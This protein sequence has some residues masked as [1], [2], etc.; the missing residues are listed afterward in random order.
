MITTNAAW[1]VASPRRAV[2]IP[3][4]VPHAHRAH[5]RTLLHTILLPSNRRRLRLDA[6]TVCWV[7]PLLRELVAVLAE[8]PPP[9]ARQRA[10]L[11]AL[12][13]DLLH[14]DTTPTLVIPQP[15]DPRLV[16]VADL[17]EADPAA[18]HS[19]LALAAAAGTSPRTLTRLIDRELG[20]TLPQW[21]TQLRL[22]YSLMLLGD[23]KSVTRTASL[24]GWRNASSFITAFR[25][26]F[27]TTP[28][29]YQRSVATV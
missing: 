5:S 24:C 9:H 26:V 7:S 19:L 16:V 18:E 10:K 13:D 29:S 1:V 17:V 12:V 27:D 25:N 6:P 4:A 3:A 2:F 23:G 11:F 21:R 28:A 20:L 22:G 14:A 8:A 15:A